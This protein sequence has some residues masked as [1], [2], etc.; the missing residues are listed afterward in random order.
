MKKL[1]IASSVAAITAA[2]VAQAAVDISGQ[3]NVAALFGSAPE[4][5]TVVDNNTTG[6]RFRIKAKKKFGNGLSI[7]TR[8][9]LQAQFAQSNDPDQIGNNSGSAD[10]I[11]ATNADGEPNDNF[12]PTPVR[13]VRYA[14]VWIAGAF[15]KVGIG[16]GDGAANGTSESYGLLNFLGGAE[17]H[18]LF[19]GLGADFSDIDGLSRQNRIRYDSP[20][21][22]GFSF[23]VSLDEQDENEVSAQYNGKVGGGKLRARIGF[24]EGDTQDTADFSIAYKFG[25]G[26]GLA[27]S[28]GEFEN[29][30][31]ITTSE[32]DWF[33]AS[34]NFG[35]KFL[36]SIGIGEEDERGADG[37][38]AGDGTNE[39]TIISLVW[40][41]VKGTEVY[42]NYGDW[43]NDLVVNDNDDDNA[44]G[45]GGRVKF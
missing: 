34:Y 21:W 1:L 15:G 41:P 6:S 7:G 33:M 12:G 44:F 42:L 40:K 24:T 22:S 28:T 36:I 32:N 5:L 29:A 9:E 23:A 13:E 18:L 31:G 37:S 2:P 3:V 4:D 17:A 38:I 10:P 30:A 14:D 45:L 27:Y 25:F 35:P 8:F 16:R 20:K 19:N 11:S 43:E 26:L 39:L